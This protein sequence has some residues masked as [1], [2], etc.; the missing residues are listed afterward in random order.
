[1]IGRLPSPQI[2]IIHCR[3]VIMDERIGMDHL[4]SHGSRDN[5]RRLTPN[6]LSG[7][8]RKNRAYPLP[9]CK[10]AV[11]HRLIKGGRILLWRA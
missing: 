11:V 9:A 2:V 8:D 10:E 7:R 6:R 3:K 1:V 4:D 5:G